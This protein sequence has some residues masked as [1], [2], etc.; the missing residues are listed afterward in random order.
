M[1]SA[2]LSDA[3]LTKGIIF[4]ISLNFSHSCKGENVWSGQPR[5]REIQSVREE[6]IT[7]RSDEVEK[8][9]I[10]GKINV[11]RTRELY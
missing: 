5:D 1:Q 8:R 11:S 10:K 7:K 4:G 3:K 6:K 9:E 2:T